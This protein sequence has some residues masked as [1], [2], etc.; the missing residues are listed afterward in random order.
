MSHP[1]FAYGFVW[2]SVA[3]AAVRVVPRLVLIVP[4][5][6]FLTVG[7]T[8]QARAGLT[9]LVPAY[10]YPGGS[11]LTYWT[12]LDQAAQTINLDVIVN[13]SS[14]P[15][16]T[17]DPNY[18]SA[19]EN[20][21]ATPHGEAFGYVSTDFGTRSLSDVESDIQGYLNLYG[22]RFAGFFLDQM[23]ILPS[24]LSYYQAIYAYIKTLD[25][26]YTVIGNPGSPF[27]NG[28][29][30]GN[31]LSTADIM[32]IFE[33]PNTAPTPGAAGFDAYPYGL[34]WF[35][36]YPSDRISNVVYDVPADA[37]NPGQSSAMLADLSKAIQLNAG[38][39][40]FTDGTGG[41][42]YAQLPSYWDQE[43]AAIAAASVPE[44]GAVAMLA[45]GCLLSSLAVALRRRAQR[46]DGC[47]I[48]S[49][50]AS[51]D[52]RS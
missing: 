27:L 6:L 45:S 19:I 42:P 38:T 7:P 18:L 15:G 34:N 32:N 41:N 29:S 33:G 44:P 31:F 52:F 14:G 40:Y 5:A 49:A 4:V 16:T 25:P 39:V 12:Q 35:Q 36:T 8:N 2:L 20:L 50:A 43:V 17:T 51:R 10:F 13:P 24:T 30:P 3:V 21:N 37:G 11:T 48:R 9:A 22:N 46:L 26:S 1:K 47:L 23:S 28:V